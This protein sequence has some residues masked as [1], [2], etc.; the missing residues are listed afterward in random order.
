[1]NQRFLTLATVVLDAPISELEQALSRPHGKSKAWDE[2]EIWANWMSR[3]P[4]GERSAHFGKQN[5]TI[6]GQPNRSS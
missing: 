4:F 6:A 5:V 3:L 1:M 2:W